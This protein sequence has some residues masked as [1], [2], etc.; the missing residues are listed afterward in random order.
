MCK[1]LCCVSFPSFSSTCFLVK[2]TYSLLMKLGIASIINFEILVYIINFLNLK[3]GLH[4]SNTCMYQTLSLSLLKGSSSS[5]TP[6]F[7]CD[8]GKSPHHY[9]P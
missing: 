7:L 2:I 9:E 4:P 5:L 1:T 8:L 3:K 6:F